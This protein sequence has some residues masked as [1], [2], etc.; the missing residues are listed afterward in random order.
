MATKK[1]GSV[2][3]LMKYN[4]WKEAFPLSFNKRKTTQKT[5]KKQKQNK[6][7]RNFKKTKQQQTKTLKKTQKNPHNG[8]KANL[9]KKKKGQIKDWFFVW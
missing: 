8:W 2:V 1:K 9:K 5:P 6:T 7:Q 3:C 4:S